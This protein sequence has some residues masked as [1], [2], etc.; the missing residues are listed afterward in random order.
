MKSYKKAAL[1]SAFALMLAA[2][3]NEQPKTETVVIETQ[4]ETTTNA[5]AASAEKAPEAAKTM[6]IKHLSGET[7]VPMNPQRTVVFDFGSLDTLEALGVNVLGIPKA[8]IPAY[9]SEYK[10]PKYLDFGALKEPDF[11][12]IHAAKPDFMIIAIRQA[13]LYEQF[14]EIAPTINYNVD[15]QNY[16][17]SLTE[18]ATTLGKLF[19]KED[20]AKAQLAELNQE[21]EKVKAKTENM[22]EKALIILANDGKISAYGPGSRF[23]FIHDV[24]GFKPADE[25]IEVSRHGQSVSFEY[26]MNLDPDYIF[27][28]DRTAVINEGGTTAK[29]TVENDL[30]KNTKAFKNGKIIYLDP[31]VWYLSGG[32]LKSTKVMIEDA[33]KALMQ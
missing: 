31:N 4:T 8:N 9:L 17:T 30:V 22:P 7:V 15:D 26:V 29:Q 28:V 20:V 6:T 24:L 3:G 19:G 1:A 23:G 11:E 12:A 16:M 14:A 13:P 10:D 25:T 18:N 21:I 32:G 5:P 2:C 33:S 27:V